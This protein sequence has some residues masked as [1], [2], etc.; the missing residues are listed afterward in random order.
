[1]PSKAH[2]PRRT[3]QSGALAASDGQV[4]WGYF[5]EM[6]TGKSRTVIDDMCRAWSRGE[7][8]RV[9]VFAYK[10]SYTDWDEK[11]LEEWMPPQI[12]YDTYVW[13]G[14]GSQREKRE[15][16]R[17]LGGGHCLRWLI[18]N[19]EAISASDR[20]WRTVVDFVQ[21]GRCGGI[22]DESTSIGE[23]SAGRTKDLLK[24]R[25]RLRLRRILTGSPATEGPL[26]LFSQTEFLRKG[27]LGFSSFYSFRARYAR[28]KTVYLSGR[29]VEAVDRDHPEGPWMNL[30]DLQQRL[31]RVSTRVLKK[32]CLDLPP[33]IFMPPT[34]FRM[35]E[36]Q[37]RIYREFQKN[38][39]VQ[40]ESMDHV[41]A[42]V[43]VAQLTKLHQIAC[44]HV[45]DE[46]GTTHR[47]PTPRTRILQELCEEAGGKTI[48]FCAWREDVALCR[49]ALERMGKVVTYIGGQGNDERSEAR[50][51][52]QDGDARFFVATQHSASRALHLTAAS[53]TIYYS[54]HQSLEL[55]EQSEARAHRDGLEHSV[56][57]ADIIAEGTVEEKIIPNLRAKIN[58]SALITGDSWRQWVI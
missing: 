7:I 21:G 16:Q 42:T 48:V 26:R 55:R 1:M 17:F 29:S 37:E 58:V 45:V 52:F 23:P 18:V 9:V 56:T 43:V 4:G 35:G 6:G 25:D 5:M 53:A 20:A 33:Q 57:Y 2:L 19:I 39:T 8:D 47:I 3:H 27:A 12:E 44:G 36:Q 51:S 31:A 46:L 38:A 41:T 54:C 32:D 30:E 40:L 28:M 22:V 49:E 13:R 50:Q 15:Y 11:H 24:L 14:M 10:H 34:R